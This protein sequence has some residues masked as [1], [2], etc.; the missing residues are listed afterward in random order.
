MNTVEQSK[1][2]QVVFDSRKTPYTLKKKLGEGGQGIVF[3][4]D[5]PN[6]VVKISKPLSNDELERQRIKIRKV[7]R[8][9]LHSLNIARPLDMLQLKSRVG[10][11]MELM[12]GLE[13]LENTL[14]KFSILTDDGNLNLDVY[15]NT[16]GF[17]RRILILKE[18]ASTLAKLHGRGMAYGDLSP[19]NI[20]ISKSV[21]HNQVWLID[22]DN[23]SIHEHNGTHYLHTPN[24]AAPELI[25][26]ESGININTDCWSFAVIA[27][28]L[29]TN[30]HP[31]NSGILVEDEDPD[32]AL[33][34]ASR[35]EY[36]WIFDTNDHS[37]IWTGVG[38]PL[39]ALLSHQLTALFERC[40]G[41]SRVHTGIVERP[42]M[43]EWHYVLQQVSQMLL[44]CQNTSCNMSFIYNKNQQCPFCDHQQS[45][46]GYLLLSHYLYVSE[47]E[48]PQENHWIKCPEHVVLNISDTLA[49]YN[50]PYSYFDMGDLKPWCQLTLTVQGLQIHP[51]PGSHIQLRN[52]EATTTAEI[53]SRRTL[54]AEQKKQQILQLCSFP[55]AG[56][57]TI[58]YPVWRFK[59]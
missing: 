39:D 40:F 58:S 45:G 49:L 28:Q 54:K 26:G 53:T 51:E 13:S 17:K 7:M 35:G 44:R 57:Q 9:N 42:C 14:D 25:R 2:S 1:N 55:L 19:N 5:H 11:V 30:T 41:V 15:R 52:K 29:L 33:Q 12:D 6:I 21:E 46:D 24:Y 20:F 31:F 38:L 3:T 10:Y 18:L 32:V 34:Q 8:A 50:E 48:L 47:P 43:S 36:P 56:Q 59:W 37:N 4:T 27:L 16:G 23:I 22:A